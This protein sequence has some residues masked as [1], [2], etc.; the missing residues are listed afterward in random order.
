[1]SSLEEA[2]PRLP[3]LAGADPSTAVRL[4]G[5]TN[6]V[7]A[8]EHDGTRYVVRVP[9]AGTSEYIDRAAEEVAARSAAAAGVNVD[10]VFFDAADGLMVTCYAEGAATMSPDGFRDLGAVA[11]A[12]DAFRRLHTKA[13]PFAIDF[14]VF[15]LIDEYR[16]LLA[17]KGLELPAVFLE[18]EA[19]AAATRGAL[20]PRG[21]L[22]PSHCD[23]L[24]ENFLDVGDRMFLIDYEYAGNNDAMWDLADLSVEGSFGPEQDAVLLRAYFGGDPRPDDEGRMVAFKAMCDLVWGLWGLIQHADGNPAEDFL[25]YGTGR[26]ERCLALMTSDDY[27]QRLA[28][29]QAA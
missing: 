8:L 23:P 7:Y 27:P 12:G 3:M 5:L 20:T 9:G 16:G 2:L 19:A 10:V 17:S 13:T 14:D 21:A 22:V 15:A 29:I 11:R 18:C 28:A 24:C 4:G 1:M 6:L 25:A 26:L